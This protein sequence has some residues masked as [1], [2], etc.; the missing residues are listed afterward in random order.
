MKTSFLVIISVVVASITILCGSAVSAK[1]M[2]ILLGAINSMTGVE[3]MV[4]NEHRWAYQQAVKDINAK[5]GVY[6]KELDKK[7]RFRLIVV[8]DQ[9]SH[10]GV[11]AAANKL[12][13]FEKVD[14]LLGTVRTPFNIN[15]GSVAEK[16]KKLYVTTALFPEMF[17]DLKYSWVA[18]SFFS[19][20]ELTSSAAACLDPIP[21]ADRALIADSRPTPG[22]FTLTS[23]VLIP[24]SSA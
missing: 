3:A 1:K 19:I 7:M 21:A 5:G 17:A 15:G 24:Y 9:S 22:P 12:I 6:V 2:E 18:N 23:S 10:T 14:F 13:E 11:I 20:R 8:D 4:G 16:H